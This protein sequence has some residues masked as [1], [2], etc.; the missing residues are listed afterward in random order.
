MGR[1]W[2]HA[3]LIAV[4]AL[5]LAGC[6]G[7]GNSDEDDITGVLEQSFTTSDPAQ[8][9]D[10][11]AKG[12]TQLNPSIAGA[13][14]PIAACKQALNPSDN[15][16]SIDVTGLKV[17]GDHASATV[18]SHGGSLAGT[19][20]TVQLVD[21]GGWKID[22][23]GEIRLVDRNAYLASF[24]RQAESNTFGTDTIT[25]RDA[26]CIAADV[27]R[28]ASTAVLQH[29]LTTGDKGFLY[30]AVTNCLG[31]GIDF[32]AITE[33]VQ[34]QLIAGGI[35]P[36][37][38]RCLAG[39]SIAGQKNATVRQFAESKKVKGRIGKV[40]KQGTFLCARTGHATG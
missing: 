4:V 39:L 30:D 38:A 36:Q 13:K 6:G 26:R 34:N 12:L 2:A 7:S 23:F 28:N 21:E 11:T 3:T 10:V 16:D 40:L 14:D 37:Q 8:C 27:R 35:D 31:G 9:E 5:A 32:I 33:L 25:P 24:D 19:A 1:A 18:R 17:D 20:V 22:G 15:A 29:S